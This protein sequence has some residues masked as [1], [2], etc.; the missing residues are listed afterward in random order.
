MN[1]FLTHDAE[2]TIAV[3]NGMG[4]SSCCMDD[5]AQ[6]VRAS[7]HHTTDAGSNPQCR[8]GFFF[9]NQISMRTLLRVSIHP[10]VQLHALTSV[11]TLKILLSMSV[12]WIMET[13]KHPACTV[14]LLLQLAFPREKNPNF[15]WENAHCGN[16]AVRSKVKKDSS[17][18]TISWEKVKQPSTALLNQSNQGTQGPF[19][20]NEACEQVVSNRPPKSR[21]STL[22]C[23]FK[24]LRVPYLVSGWS[25]EAS[26][27]WFTWGALWQTSSQIIPSTGKNHWTI[28]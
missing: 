21:A 22:L 19:M 11:C 24:L 12:W 8:R 5:S 15:P 16:A 27:S 9:Q 13:L 23:C 1:T 25:L 2:Q 3:N 17:I 18:K 10:H 14:A 7:D 20:K 28:L 26:R 6:L 4:E